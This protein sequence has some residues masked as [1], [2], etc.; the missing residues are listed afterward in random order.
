[1]GSTTVLTLDLTT[2]IGQIWWN[3]ADA[4][5]QYEGNANFVN[6]TSSGEKYTFGYDFFKNYVSDN[7]YVTR[8]FTW[9]EMGN[10]STNKVINLMTGDFGHCISGAVSKYALLYKF[11]D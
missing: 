9:A 3:S 2:G 8:G 11:C 1:M 5:S 7:V 10:A 4:D 6:K